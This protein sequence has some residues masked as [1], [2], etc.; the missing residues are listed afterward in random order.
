VLTDGSKGT[1]HAEADLEQLVAIRQEEQ[2]AAADVVGAAAVH[3]LGEP[4]GELES[5]LDQ[6]AAVCEVI[7]RVRPE[8]VLGHDPWK[9]YRLHPDHF[10]AG[11]LTVDGIVAARDPHFFPGRGDPHRP[12]RLLLFE[13]DVVDHLEDAAVHLATKVEALLEHRTQWASTFGIDPGAADLGAFAR[14][15]RE[16]GAAA[17]ALGGLELAEAFKLV[18]PL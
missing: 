12:E 6:R 8:I 9:R 18:E 10:H 16:E 5:G 7:R 3:F 17:G 4:D 11:R 14:Q 13:A 1:W 15:V 2:R